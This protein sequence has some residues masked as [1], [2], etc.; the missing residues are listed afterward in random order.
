MYLA[1]K[2]YK[3]SNLP[4]IPEVPLPKELDRIPSEKIIGLIGEPERILEIRQSRLQ[5]L[6]LNG[7]SKY[8]D[9]DRIREEV[10]YSKEVFESLG[11]HVIQVDD[12]SIEEAAAIIECVAKK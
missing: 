7:D 4:L 8:A 11:A 10:A 9:L 1:N 3:V 5:S 6:G 12:K 2:S